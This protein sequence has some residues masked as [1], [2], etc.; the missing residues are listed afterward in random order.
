MNT[1]IRFFLYAALI[2]LGACLIAALT[3]GLAALAKTFSIPAWVIVA[4]LVAG[5]AGLLTW[6]HSR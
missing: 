6:E 1:L 4:V 2:L 5:Y 3:A